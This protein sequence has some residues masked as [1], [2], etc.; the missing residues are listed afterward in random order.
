MA[1][2]PDPNCRARVRARRASSPRATREDSLRG[3]LAAPP[4]RRPARTRQRAG[5]AAQGQ[6]GRSR[7]MRSGALSRSHNPLQI[8]ADHQILT[9]SSTRLSHRQPVLNERRWR[10]IR[11]YCVVR[12]PRSGHPTSPLVP[13]PVPLPS[14]SGRVRCSLR[15][16]MAGERFG[17]LHRFRQV[18]PG[19]DGFGLRRALDVKRV[20]DPL[21]CELVRRQTGHGEPDD[22]GRPRQ[23]PAIRSSLG[24]DRLPETPNRRCTPPTPDVRYARGNRPARWRSG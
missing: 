3:S 20:H 15:P 18:R 24:S 21:R 6:S 1:P 2:P 14:P 9:P 10:S 19:V 22:R 16:G 4:R 11:R 13:F 23:S 17:A 5:G 12:K 7:S 8:A